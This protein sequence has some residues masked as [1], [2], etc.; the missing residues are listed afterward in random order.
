MIFYRLQTLFR[1]CASIYQALNR[2][3]TSFTVS[4]NPSCYFNHFKDTAT[5]TII[6]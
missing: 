4:A 1:F 2:Y 3:F 6:E 5:A